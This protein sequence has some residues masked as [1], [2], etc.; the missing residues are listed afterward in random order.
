MPFLGIF[1][2]CSTPEKGRKHAPPLAFIDENRP[3]PYT[4]LMRSSTIFLLLILLLA[5]LLFAASPAKA[6]ILPAEGNPPADRQTS[7][8]VLGATLLLIATLLP[9]LLAYRRWIKRPPHVR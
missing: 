2:S 5:G 8:I 4:A 9:P 3:A 1:L 7:E 6:A